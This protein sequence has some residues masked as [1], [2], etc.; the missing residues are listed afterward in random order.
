MVLLTAANSIEDAHPF[1][2]AAAGRSP[3]NED[4]AA[5]AVWGIPVAAGEPSGRWPG[6]YL[7]MPPRG[8]GVP[9][10]FDD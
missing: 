6:H 7:L 10:S 8:G 3:E 2:Q 9:G 5:A 4:T 1:L